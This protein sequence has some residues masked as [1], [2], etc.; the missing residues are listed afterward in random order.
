[1]TETLV[2]FLLGSAVTACLI[3]SAFFA[4]FWRRTRDLLFLAFAVAFLLFGA[5]WAMVAVLEEETYPAV[6]LFRLL[7]FA[8][9]IAGVIG[10]NRSAIAAR[11]S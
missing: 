2:S 6:Y 7:G 8:I 1:M 4:R 3:V 10:K 5:N 9:I 11:D